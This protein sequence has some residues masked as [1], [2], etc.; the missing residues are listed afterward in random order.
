ML[1]FV[2]SQIDSWCFREARPMGAVG[3]TAIESL[4]PPPAHT[5]VGACR[6]LIGDSQNINW[7]DF[8]AN[9]LPQMQALIGNGEHTGQLRFTYPYLRGRING[10]LQRL[11]P[12]PAFLL[13]NQEGLFSLR[14]GNKPVQTDL[15]KVLLPELPEG[16]AGAKPLDTHWITAD[17][18]A[19]L[20]AGKLPQ[21]NQII[22]LDSLL[23]KEVRLG[24]GRNNSMASVERGMLYQTEHLRLSE[25]GQEQTLNVTQL[26]LVIEVQGVPADIANTLQQHPWQIRL[27]GEGRMAEVQ[28]KALPA[29]EQ[30]VPACQKHAWLYLTAPADLDSWLPSQ[31][32]PIEVAGCDS[33]QGEIG[34]KTLLIR[35]FCAGKSVKL[36]GWDSVKRQPKPVKS[37]VPAG[38]CYFIECENISGLAQVLTHN[39]L[40]KQTDFGFGA[41]VLLPVVK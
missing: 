32:S 40:G 41:A 26:E 22:S 2:F 16:G 37:L 21:A 24:I 14:I 7:Q 15:G 4:F 19:S 13:S 1:Q 8:A 36:G 10:K 28:V 29:E 6:T 38:A 18:F 9:K 30:P 11:Y 31:F 17:G 23:T 34:G 33:W 27:G 20:Q 25:Q 12:A 3:G 5:L 35:A 39:P